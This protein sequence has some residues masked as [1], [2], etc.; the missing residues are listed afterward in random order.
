[1]TIRLSPKQRKQPPS[2]AA[3]ACSER[4][5]MDLLHL[6]VERLCEINKN[7][8]R[9]TNAERQ[10]LEKLRTI[11]EDAIVDCRQNRTGP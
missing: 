5:A 11:M 2:F 3:I 10:R 6:V 9:K 8:S 1:M 4:H 7:W